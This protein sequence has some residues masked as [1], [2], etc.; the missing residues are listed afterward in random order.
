RLRAF[1]DVDPD[2]RA[3]AVDRTEHGILRPVPEQPA[4]VHDADRRAHIRELAQDMGRDQD[5]RAAG[6][7]LLEN[8]AQVAARYRVHAA[9]RL[10]EQKQLRLVKQ[11][12]RRHDALRHAARER[13]AVYVSL[14]GQPD[15]LETRVDPLA[16]PA[17][18]QSV[19]VR[20][21]IEELPD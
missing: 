9:G 3:L 14:V 11:R 21:E 19:A 10:V 7:E 12:L 18:F 13:A 1:D 2:L 15:L 16:L 17:A 5:R 4:E 6:R 8:A 20:V